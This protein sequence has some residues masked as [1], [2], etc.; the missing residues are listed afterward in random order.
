M[1]Q[2]CLTSDEL[3]TAKAAF[4]TLNGVT[5]SCSEQQ[6]QVYSRAMSLAPKAALVTFAAVSL[7]LA[8]VLLY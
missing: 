7:A 2:A 6:I 4:A 3:S 5:S 8:A 1:T